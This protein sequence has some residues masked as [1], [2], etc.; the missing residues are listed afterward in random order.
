MI[1]VIY[2]PDGTI[3]TFFE[4]DAN[5]QLEDGESLLEL[6]TTFEE[7]AARFV[8]SC[9]GKTCQTIYVP[10]GAPPVEVQISAPGQASVD[11]DVNGQAQT[12]PL[13]AGVGTLTLPTE[14]PALFA[15]APTDR[16]AFCMA[17]CGSILVV[18]QD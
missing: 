11:V 9:Q 18:V 7:Y 15:L 16:V 3:K 6:P 17:G 10:V 2:N 14:A 13:S 8:L 12:V 5:W 1:K 4:G